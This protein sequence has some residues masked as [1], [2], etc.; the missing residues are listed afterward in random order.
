MR[1]LV[2]EGTEWV[3]LRLGELP[4]TQGLPAR[5]AKLVFQH[6]DGRIAGFGGCNRIMGDY[7]V[8]GPKLRI[9]PVAS[10]RMACANGMD[11][12]AAF[13]AALDQVASWQIHDSTLQLSDRDGRPVATFQGGD[14]D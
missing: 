14:V 2:L 10:T 11:Q 7:H 12:E 9:G 5:R 4:V 6:G 8:D 3:L 1:T 13:L